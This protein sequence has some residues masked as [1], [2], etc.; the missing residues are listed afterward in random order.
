MKGLIRKDL[1][2]LRQMAITMLLLGGFYVALG[3]MNYRDGGMTN[4]FPMLAMIVTMMIPLTCGGFD[5]QC[6]WDSFGNALPVSRTQVVA[7]RYLVTL[8]VMA[9]TGALAVLSVLVYRWLFHT[10]GNAADCAIPLVIAILY[11]SISHPVVYKFGVNKARYIT[12]ALMILPLLAIGGL[13]GSLMFFGEEV[14]PS[15][16]AVSASDAEEVIVDIDVGAFLEAHALPMALGGLV[17]ALV[18][19][20]LSFL[21]SVAIYKKKNQ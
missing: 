16:L 19:F 1:L 5:E 17:V 7:A 12:I 11:A 20:G 8:I 15:D 9:F 6:D 14:S 10:Q 21:L 13:I 3:A 4:Y 18:I 2:G